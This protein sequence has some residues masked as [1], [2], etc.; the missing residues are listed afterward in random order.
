MFIEVGDLKQV[1]QYSVADGIEAYDLEGPPP[2]TGT[3]CKINLIKNEFRVFPF[4]DLICKSLYPGIG[5][6]TEVSVNLGA[7][8]KDFILGRRHECVG[9]PSYP[10]WEPPYRNYYKQCIIAS[11]TLQTN[12]IRSNGFVI[13]DGKVVAKPLYAPGR[14]DPDYVSLGISGNYHCLLVTGTEAKV[15]FLRVED[16]EGK[17][18]ELPSQSYGI[19]SPLIVRDGQP[20]RL[21]RCAPPFRDFEGRLNGD[22]VD[23]PPLP[24]DVRETDRGPTVTSFTAFGV[25]ADGKLVMASIFEGE[26]GVHAPVGRGILASVMAELLCSEEYQ[27]Q[28]AILGGGAADTQQYVK[29]RKWPT[30]WTSLEIRIA[31]EKGCQPEFRN[32]PVRPKPP[33]YERGEVEGVRGL[34][35]IA[36]VLPR[37]FS[38]CRFGLFDYF[39]SRIAHYPQSP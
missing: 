27:V 24:A 31:E 34:G 39:A 6:F 22:W 11:N 26:W 33:V 7:S 38:G 12:F 29:G 4:Y 2:L 35:A 28:H 1:R 17:N 25:D 32:A 10:S 18:T 36:G 19:A 8:V 13:V 21:E 30:S 15:E 23:W 37:A 16:P 20:V 14:D 9:H 5:C 3:V